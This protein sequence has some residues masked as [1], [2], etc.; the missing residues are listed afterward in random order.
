MGE[1]LLKTL[2]PLLFTLLRSRSVFRFRIKPGRTKL[3]PVTSRT[4]NYVLNA[5]G[6]SSARG[7]AR[8]DSLVYG[9]VNRV[10]MSG[11]LLNCRNYLIFVQY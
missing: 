7:L 1:Q 8:S 10:P 5:M 4:S 2:R 11:G 6:L 3:H 9:N